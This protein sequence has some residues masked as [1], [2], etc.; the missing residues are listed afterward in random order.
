MLCHSFWPCS[1]WCWQSSWSYATHS[2]LVHVD[3]DT[4]VDTMPHIPAWFML[5]LTQIAGHKM[6][7][8]PFMF[9][10]FLKCQL[11][12]KWT[13][14]QGKNCCVFLTPCQST[15]HMKPPC[16]PSPLSP[17][18]A[19]IHFEHVGWLT[20]WSFDWLTNWLTDQVVLFKPCL[21]WS[22]WLID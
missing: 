19:L 5:M 9:L 18:L 11:L 20:D 8:P 2:S 3:A 17:V 1:C 7:A 22:D 16:S 10:L 21:N 15:G 12:T 6:A 13:R 4:V 14:N